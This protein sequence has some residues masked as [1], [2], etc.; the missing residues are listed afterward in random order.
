MRN[1]RIKNGNIPIKLI[2]TPEQLNE[3]V[4]HLGAFDELAF[5]T[6]FDKFYRQY[7]FNLLL[8]QIFDGH[9]CFLVDTVTI[10][11]LEPLWAIFENKAICK[12]V[13]SGREDVDLL[14]RNGCTPQ[15]IFDV[16]IAAVL[17]NKTDLSYSGLIKTEFGMEIDKAPQT[18][19]W[20]NRPLQ[21]SQLIYASNDVIHL[22]RLKELFMHSI[23][24]NGVS[25]IMHEENLALEA[26]TTKDY[27]PKLSGKQMKLFSTYSRRKLMEFKILIDMFGQQFN[28]PPYNIAGDTVL[29]EI[30]KDRE[31]FLKDPFAKGF[32]RMAIENEK[33]RTAFS[34]LVDSIDGNIPWENEKGRTVLPENFREAKKGQLKNGDSGLLPFRAFIIGKYGEIAS[35][36]IL[37]GLS[38]RMVGNVINWEGTK[39]YQKKLYDEFFNREII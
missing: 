15:N 13:F 21:L 5:D 20:Q 33:F 30:I 18:S 22:F 3:L 23:R 28:L 35:T 9:T 29:E 2:D 1:T 39:G 32:N 14:K 26:S 11:S 38:K 25:G 8:I 37:G 4:K 6:E 19:N 36:V 27:S 16:Q 10:K 24:K 17:C 7:G 12:L 34:E 31:P